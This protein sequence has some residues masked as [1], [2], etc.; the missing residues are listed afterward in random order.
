MGRSIS[1]QPDQL[2]WKAG[3]FTG[4]AVDQQD[5]WVWSSGEAVTMNVQS[6][7]LCQCLQG[8]SRSDFEDGEGQKS[9][10]KKDKYPKPA[11]E[12]IVIL[13]KLSPGMVRHLDYMKRAAPGCDIGTR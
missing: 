8:W 1:V 7:S 9:Y 10:R 6:R 5:K 4:E 3:W 13:K 12:N 11:S 2:N